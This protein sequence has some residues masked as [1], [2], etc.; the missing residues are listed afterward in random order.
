MVH[1]TGSASAEKISTVL[2][3]PDPDNKINKAVA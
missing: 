1:M 3:S 2:Q